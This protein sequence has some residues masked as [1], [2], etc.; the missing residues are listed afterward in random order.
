[1]PTQAPTGHYPIDATHAHELT[2]LQKQ[3]NAWAPD[4][5][6][7]LDAIG[8][9]PGWDCLD[10]G[11]G[12]CGL[13]RTLADRV[14]PTGQV[15]G[16]EYNPDFI[17]IARRD[18]PA[19]VRI[20][21]GDAYAT[22]FPDGA[23]D[24][25]HM[26]FLASTSGQLDRLL[27]EAARVVKPGGVLALEE[28]DSSPM[29]V[30]PPH[31][32]YLRIKAGMEAIFPVV[33]GQ[34]P[35]AHRMYRILLDLGLQ[36]VNFRLGIVGQRPGDPWQEFIPDTAHSVRSALIGGGH[37]TQDDLERD[38]ADLRAHLQKPGT[39]FVSFMLVQVWGRKPA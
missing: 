15:T 12:P 6:A 17:E 7:L 3:D 2:R 20:V 1:M 11:C 39:T 5:A 16:L 32:A 34:D 28:A 25:V 21:Q 35:A 38:I 9:G 36:D 4:T 19:N 27:A 10:L 18:A 33:G 30:Y 29:A 24:L 13:T 26:R 23:F 8:V 31:P 22:G 14:G 37:F